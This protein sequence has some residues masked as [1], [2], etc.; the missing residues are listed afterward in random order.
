MSHVVKD[1]DSA[2]R[3]KGGKGEKPRDPGQWDG[4]MGCCSLRISKARKSPL[5]NKGSFVVAVIVLLLEGT[6][7]ERQ[8]LGVR[9]GIE[10]KQ[11]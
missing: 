3:S 6:Q 1:E 8:I 7:E 5:A 10:E 9:G 4:M 2:L 11:I